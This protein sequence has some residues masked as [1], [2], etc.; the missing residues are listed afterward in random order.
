MESYV[1]SIV[2][3]ELHEENVTFTAEWDMSLFFM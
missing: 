2:E 1:M 3:Q